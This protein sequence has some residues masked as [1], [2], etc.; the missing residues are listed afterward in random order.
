M[1]DAKGLTMVAAIALTGCVLAAGPCAAAGVLVQ[2]FASQ[3]AFQ[4]SPFFAF[5]NDT[6]QGGPG[7]NCAQLVVSC[8][9][10]DL[11]VPAS[12]AG[13]AGNT[14]VTPEVEAAACGL[15]TVFGGSS[16]PAAYDK[17][18]VS[19]GNQSSSSASAELVLS[20]PA[21]ATDSTGGYLG[22]DIAIIDLGQ[23]LA[24]GSGVRS[25]ER[26]DFAVELV[27]DGLQ[28]LAGSMTNSGGNYINVI[29]IDLT[30]TP[31]ILESIDRL[32]IT[33]A[34]GVKRPQM[35]SLDIDGAINLNP[36]IPVPTRTATWGSLK[37]SYR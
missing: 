28:F 26:T 32:Y 21:V 25:Q 22:Y 14:V 31:G 15:P 11:I 36:A 35:G 13:A 24:A 19:L 6:L 9:Q 29:L 3:A 37:A 12:S 5:V 20:L 2:S 23:D 16:D 33:D 7:P 18:F 34:S 8:R 1:K 10:G 4:A 27:S 17:A 30:G